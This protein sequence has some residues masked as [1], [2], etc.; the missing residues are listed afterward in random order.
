MPPAAAAIGGSSAMGTS[1]LQST[2]TE[3]G[4]PATSRT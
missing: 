3:L 2:C 4:E 1:E